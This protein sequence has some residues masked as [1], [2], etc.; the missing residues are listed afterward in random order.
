MRAR[1]SLRDT[2]GDALLPGKPIGEIPRLRHFQDGVDASRDLRDDVNDRI[3]GCLL[4][5]GGCQVLRRS[6]DSSGSILESGIVGSNRLLHEGSLLIVEVLAQ[7]E[8]LL[9]LR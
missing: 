7:S 4:F 5:Y 1:N 2:L 6:L 9:P 3:D 8:E